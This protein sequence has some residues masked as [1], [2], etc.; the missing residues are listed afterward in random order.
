MN[1]WQQQNSPRRAKASGLPL[2]GG[3]LLELPIE[4]PPKAPVPRRM[5]LQASKVVV[6]VNAQL[7]PPMRHSVS[8]T[9]QVARIHVTH[10]QFDPI[11]FLKYCIHDLHAGTP[12]V[13]SKKLG[14]SEFNMQEARNQ[15]CAATAPAVPHTAS[16]AGSLTWPQ[17]RTKG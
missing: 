12:L 13:T 16:E 10:Y 3:C 4:G 8:R 14:R 11:L 1:V 6:D 9:K 5:R 15:A 7:Q 17:R 2:I